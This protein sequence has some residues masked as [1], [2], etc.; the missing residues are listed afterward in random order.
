MPLDRARALEVTALLCVWVSY[1]CLALL[2]LCLLQVDEI[3]D[4][5]IAYETSYLLQL[6]LLQT[7]EGSLE[8]IK[9]Y[10]VPVVE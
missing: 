7:I 6:V 10:S 5:A 3:C 4:V 9:H 8:I 1:V 2:P